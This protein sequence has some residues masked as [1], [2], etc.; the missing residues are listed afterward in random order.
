[1]STFAVCCLTG[2][3]ADQPVVCAKSGLVFE[4]STIEKYI[5]IN[6]TCPVT[7]EPL[8]NSDLVPIRGRSPLRSSPID[9]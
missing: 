8:E 1:M 4:K 6:H 2:K 7:G 5:D 3:P 9:L